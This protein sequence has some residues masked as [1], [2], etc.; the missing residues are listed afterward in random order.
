M[1]AIELVDHHFYSDLN[2][3]DQGVRA[4]E[5]AC[6]HRAAECITAFAVLGRV[7]TQNMWTRSMEWHY[8]RRIIDRTLDRTQ[9]V[10][11]FVSPVLL[12]N[13]WKP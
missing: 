10:E 12:V 8:G 3:Q 4:F 5:E 9:R 2:S 11:E 13:L 6:L 1:I 7:S